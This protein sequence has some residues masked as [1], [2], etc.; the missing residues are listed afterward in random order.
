M[1]RLRESAAL[2]LIQVNS[3]A[4]NRSVQRQT[5]DDDALRRPARKRLREAQGVIDG[6]SG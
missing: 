4:L 3:L 5:D 2:A 6:N 1:L